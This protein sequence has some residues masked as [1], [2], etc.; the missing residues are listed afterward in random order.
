MSTETKKGIIFR[1]AD[2]EIW[3]GYFNNGRVTQFDNISDFEGIYQELPLEKLT[4]VDI[5]ILENDNIMINDLVTFEL[6]QQLE[7]GDFVPR[8]VEYMLEDLKFPSED[9]DN[10][11]GSFLNDIGKTH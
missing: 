4:I 2:T 6:G 5:K 3:L 9:T 7:T 11:F 8:T 1:S 10:M